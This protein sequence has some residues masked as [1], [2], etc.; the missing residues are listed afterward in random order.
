MLG[1]VGESG[2]G[3]ST[4]GRLALGLIKPTAGSG[5]LRGN[6]DITSPG[7]GQELEAPCGRSMQMVF[8]DPAT[9]LNPR[10]NVG[11]ILAEPLVIH[12]MATRSQARKEVERLLAE[13]G[14][15]ARARPAL[16]PPVQR[17]PAPAHRHRPGP[18]PAAPAWWWPT[19]R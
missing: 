15:A 19:S 14:P 10:I 1:L 16:S 4:L 6:Q 2:C 7:P 8:Q 11:S 3:K 5:A 18:G 12:G 9:S 13:V 17:R